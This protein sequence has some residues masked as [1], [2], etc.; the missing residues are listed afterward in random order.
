MRIPTAALVVAALVS[1]AVAESEPAKPTVSFEIPAG[2]TEQPGAADDWMKELRGMPGTRAADAQVF[3]SNDEVVQLTRVTWSMKYPV[4]LDQGSIERADLAAVRSAAKGASHVSDSRRWNGEQL[5][6][7]AIDD[8]PDGIR[9]EHFRIYGADT[10][11]V[12]HMIWLICAGPA[13][14]L[15]TCEKAQRTLKVTVPN[16]ATLAADVPV[17]VAASP[18]DE[19]GKTLGER[20]AFK[21]G[22]YGFFAVIAGLI[23]LAIRKWG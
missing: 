14:Q 15:G 22:Y 1:T 10:D 5:V 3:A 21:I 19:E 17:H 13:D 11:N 16:Q 2:F 9:V 12:L 23:V 6:A 7:E 18:D 8:A 4:A 20:I